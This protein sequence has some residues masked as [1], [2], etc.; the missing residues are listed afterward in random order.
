MRNFKNI[1]FIGT[2]LALAVMLSALALG[3][4][5]KTPTSTTPPAVTLSSITVTPS[6]PN[7]LAVGGTQQFTAAGTY[8]DGKQSDITTQ[9]SWTSSNTTVA[10]ISASGLATGV[11]EGSSVISA[12]LNN[13][14]SPAVNLTVIVPVPELS[15]IT[16]MPESADNLT[17][18]ATLQLTAKATYS[19]NSNEDVTSK[20]T[21]ASS[22]NTVALISPTGLVTGVSGGTTNITAS[23]SGITS[24]KLVLTVVPARNLTSIAVTPA[25]PANLAVGATQQFVATGTYSDG[26][27]ADISSQVTWTSTTANVATISTLGLATGV[28]SGTTGITASLSQ[29]TSTAITLTVA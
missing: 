20:V 12:S 14:T 28:A 8:S 19:N 6:S 7:N 21:W 9:V 11:A 22:D 29:I 2:L 27:T 15:T 23:W 13:K 16:I 10:T 5:T 24:P 26:S 25:S 1:I 17:V 3:C 18:G 4:T